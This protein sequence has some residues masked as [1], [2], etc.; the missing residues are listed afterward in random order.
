MAVGQNPLR[1]IY[2][3]LVFSCT[4]WT[5]EASFCWQGTRPAPFRYHKVMVKL[6]FHYAICDSP[7]VF[8]Y[9]MPSESHVH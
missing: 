6:N 2:R 3:K 1:E 9:S 7:L 8:H 4:T 5:L